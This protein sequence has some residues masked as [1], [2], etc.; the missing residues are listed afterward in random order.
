MQI[1]DSNGQPVKVALDGRPIEE[2]LA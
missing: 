2:I 1:P